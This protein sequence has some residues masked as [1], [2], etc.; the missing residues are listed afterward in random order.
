MREVEAGCVLVRLLSEARLLMWIL[1][2]RGR[3]QN[4]ARLFKA[5]KDTEASTPGV[6]ALDNDDPSNYDVTAL[7]H[8]WEVIRWER[9][10]GLSDIQNRLFCRYYD[11]PWF[12]LIGDD[13]VPMTRH[14]DTKLVEAAGTD[15]IAYAQDGINNARQLTHAVIAGNLVR[16]MDFLVLPGLHRL[17]GDNVWTEIGRSRGVLRYLPDVVLEHWH[18]SNGKAPYDATYRKDDSDGDQAVYERWLSQWRAKRA[19]PDYRAITSMNQVGEP[20]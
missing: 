10:G 11:S 14:W 20:S 3:P 18:F 16:E 15:G 2:S 19:T 6:L 4:I 9:G 13:V 5:W 12:G 7:P 8:N 17:Y 1:P